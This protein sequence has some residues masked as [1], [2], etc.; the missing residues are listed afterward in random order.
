[1]FSTPPTFDR[2]SFSS[3]P[4]QTFMPDEKTSVIKSLISVLTSNSAGCDCCED[5]YTLYIFKGW[6]LDSPV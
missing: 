4:H 1:M 6:K 2:F 5:I 3:L